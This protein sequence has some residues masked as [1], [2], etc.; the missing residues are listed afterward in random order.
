MRSLSTLALFV[1]LVFSTSSPAQI[2]YP[3]LPNAAKNNLI[4]VAKEQE[5]LFV[6]RGVRFN[7]PELQEIVDRV[8][9][10]VF[11][12]VQDEYI[13]F[14]VYLIRDPSP[15]MFSLADGQI[16]VH[17]GLLA[18]LGNEAQLASVLAHEAHHV[19][20]HHHIQ[21]NNS[22]RK[23]ANI[24]GGIAVAL[25]K[26]ESGQS[27]PNEWEGGTSYSSNIGGNPQSVFSGNQE[28]EADAAS[29][30]L[31]GRAGHPP[32]ASLQ[33]LASIRA[34]PELSTASPLASFTSL[35]ALTE[36]QG[37]LQELVDGLPSRSANATETFDLSAL[38][39][40]RVIE[41][42]I[43][44]YIRLDRP[45]TAVELVDAMIAN[46]PDAFMY[47]E[48]FLYAAKGDSHVALGPRPNH[49]P[50]DKSL[51]FINGK[52]AAKTRTE[53]FDEYME[54]EQGPE[55]LARNHESAITAY[56]TAMQL[57]ANDAR[58]YRGLGDLYFENNELKRS[59]RNYIKYLK[60]SPDAL[61]RQLVLQNLQHIKAELSKQKET[62]K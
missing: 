35:D 34:D 51:W 31:I 26:R 41:M 25:N 19:A 9:E 21:A 17:T 45:G 29:I 37:Q 2:N 33:A 15:L 39:L 46:Q 42:T 30:G 56:K 20:A 47:P 11:P 62:E 22:R 59:G 58:A 43:D 55:R 54:T 4:K 52:R 36:R 57:D 44:D 5:E 61:D 53:V 18:R 6:R 14:R 27:F 40:R 23:K 3:P 24:A 49:E 10:T 16:Y 7:D 48:A 60:L 50:P 8:G 28:I 38:V 1:G 12:S 13:D 32:I